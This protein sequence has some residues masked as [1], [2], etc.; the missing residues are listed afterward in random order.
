MK[1]VPIVSAKVARSGRY[2]IIGGAATR[3]GGIATLYRIVGTRLVKVAAVKL[4]SKG[5]YTFG[6]RAL[7]RGYY[8]VLTRADK[9]WAAG[10]SVRIV[11]R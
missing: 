2:R 4:T 6:K 1:V 11:V 7:P 5:V 8:R 9:Y 3:I 10:T